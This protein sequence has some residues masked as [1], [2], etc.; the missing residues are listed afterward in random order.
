[1]FCQSVVA[2]F[3]L[4]FTWVFELLTATVRFSEGWHHACWKWRG[5]RMCY[6]PTKETFSFLLAHLASWDESWVS[7]SSRSHPLFFLISRGLY[8]LFFVFV[9]ARKSIHFYSVEFML[10]FWLVYLF[11]YALFDIFGSREHQDWTWRASLCSV[12]RGMFQTHSL[13]PALRFSL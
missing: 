12:H 5:E 9:S 3:F 8:F 10:T 4:F 13:E 1:M 6:D 2:W 11:A 7:I